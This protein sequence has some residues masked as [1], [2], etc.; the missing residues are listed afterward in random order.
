MEHIGVIGLGLL[1]GAMAERL[2]ASEYHVTGY[3]LD[4]QRCDAL[5]SCGVHIAENAQA[6]VQSANRV[7]LCLPTTEIVETVLDSVRPHIR[8]RQILID[9]T[10]GDPAHMIRIAEKI[11]QLGAFYLDASVAG[12]SELARQGKVV[13]LVGGDDREV[14]R[15]AY[16]FQTLAL[17]AIHLGPAGSGAKFKLVHNLLLGLHRAVLAEGLCLA[18]ALNLDR[19]LVLNVLKETVAYSRVMDSK[20]DKMVQRDFSPQATLSQHLKDVKLMLAA[21][22]R[23]GQPLPLTDLHCQLLTQAEIA[24]FGTEDNSAIIRM[25]ERQRGEA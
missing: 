13:L 11:G 24:G 8:S 20:G 14:E 12:S 25:F 16:L 15:C 7:I 1:G 18:D 5:K 23:T 4:R 22:E 17:K 2:S 19:G 6:V 10:T 21:G 3:D 9:A